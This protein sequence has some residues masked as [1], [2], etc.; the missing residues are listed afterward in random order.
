[1]LLI[2]ACAPSAAEVSEVASPDPIQI[3]MS[4][5]VLDDADGGPDSPLSSQ[6]QV[7][8]LEEIAQRMNDIWG[9]Q[10]L[11]SS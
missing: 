11:N 4:L 7:S 3:S 1:M 6:R 10:A 9:K 8:D 5:Y 2:S